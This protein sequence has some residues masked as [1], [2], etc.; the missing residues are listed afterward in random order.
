MMV[1]A[2]L[3]PSTATTST[4]STRLGTAMI[5]SMSRVMATS[6]IGPVIA[7]A[8]PSA[9]PTMNDTHITERPMNSDTRAPKMRRDS[10][11]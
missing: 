7:A 9:T 5:K 8:S 3:G 4:A 10:M 6:T 1:L 2:R 11:S